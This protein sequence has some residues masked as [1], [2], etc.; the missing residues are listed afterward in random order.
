MGILRRLQRNERSRQQFEQLAREHQQVVFNAALRLTR[1]HADAEDLTQEAFVKA[2][3]AFD[4][5]RPGTNFRAW[6]FKIVT[7]TH[8]NRYR[9]TGRFPKTVGWEELTDG[10]QR[11]FYW[12]QSD[13]PGPEPAVVEQYLDDPVGLALSDLPDE[14]RLAVI[15][16]DMFELNY[17]E[18]AAV[19][20]VPLGTVR[21][22]IF[23]GRQLLRQR[24]REYAQEH[25]YI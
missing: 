15:L 8:I 25:G 19:L 10:G 9:G 3:I 6:M 20:Q 1:S 23:R 24:L 17:R 13:E 16:C 12:Q 5:F 21:S 11:D 14:F 22:R 18:I 2:Y 4:Q 7:T